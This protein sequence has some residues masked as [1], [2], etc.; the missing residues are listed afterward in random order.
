MVYTPFLKT[1]GH[2]EYHREWRKAAISNTESFLSQLSQ[3]TIVSGNLFSNGTAHLLKP[4]SVTTNV[5]GS[6]IATAG[7]VGAAVV[8]HVAVREQTLL[9]LTE[10]GYI[11]LYRHQNNTTV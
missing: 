1:H 9:F 4:F 8:A 11:S 7:H 2:F 5:V 3:G 6:W 10:R